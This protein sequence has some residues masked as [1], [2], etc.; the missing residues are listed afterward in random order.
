MDTN[1]VEGEL[2]VTDIVETKDEAG[3]DTTD[4]KAL[5]LHNQGIAKRLKTKLAKGS[6]KK[7]E[8]EV[9]TKDTKT[10]DSKDLSVKAFLRSAGITKKE[11][12]EFALSKAKKWSVEVDELVDDTDFQE[13]L[14]KFRAKQ[15]NVEAVKGVEGDKSGS[16]V[17]ET[18][19]Y[20]QAK[21]TPPTPT[22]VPDRAKRTKIIKEMMKLADTSGKKFYN[23]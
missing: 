17:K 16:P 18:T 15:A 23:E 2:Q 11:E 20:W 4:W 6:E 3:N 7:T 12:V 19:E 8:Q 22:D 5:A 9:V 21:G 13:S 1:E 10:D 14:E